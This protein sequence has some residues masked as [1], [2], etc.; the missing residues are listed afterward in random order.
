ML[1]PCTSRLYEPCCATRRPIY[2]TYTRH[3]Y[4]PA[5]TRAYQA[6]RT[7]GDRRQR[8]DLRHIED[9]R[10][11]QESTEHQEATNG[12]HLTVDT[13][14]PTL[15]FV[16]D[17]PIIFHWLLA[18]STLVNH[19][20]MRVHHILQ[21]NIGQWDNIISRPDLCTRDDF[22]SLMLLKVATKRFDC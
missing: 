4:I 5:H 22:T 11:S 17:V 8:G 18:L 3:M 14:R 20:S 15:L 10:E 12:L 13:Q 19:R 9:T 6:M 16:E 21:R 2:H 7:S 1:P